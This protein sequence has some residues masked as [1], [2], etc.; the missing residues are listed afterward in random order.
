[1][2]GVLLG[3]LLGTVDGNLL[4]TLLGAVDG[5]LLGTLLGAVDGNLLGTLLGAVD[6]SLL[7]AAEASRILKP[8]AAWQASQPSTDRTASNNTVCSSS[9]VPKTNSVA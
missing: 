3:T 9:V 2:D 5:V 8:L 6:G 1:M 4:G 7:G